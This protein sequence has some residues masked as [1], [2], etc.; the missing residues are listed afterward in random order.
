MDV[1]KVSD[2]VVDL[3]PEGGKAGGI[4][5]FAGTPEAMIKKSKGYT[6]EY[7]KKEM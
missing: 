3:G 5:Q 2:Y 6:A 7:L 1:I 4:I